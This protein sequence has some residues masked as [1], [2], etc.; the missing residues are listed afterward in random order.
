GQIDR[1]RWI[2][3]HA[4]ARR[5]RTG[6]RAAS[7]TEAGISQFTYDGD[8][9]CSH[10][11]SPELMGLGSRR[12]FLEL[13]EQCVQLERRTAPALGEHRHRDIALTIERPGDDRGSGLAALAPRALLAARARRA[14]LARLAVLAILALD[15]ELPALARTWARVVDTRDERATVK[16]DDVER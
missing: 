6:D 4:V 13:F 12:F 14:A 2:A 3:G 16:R 9:D 7:N 15:E 5:E 10:I 11:S 1:M 8:G